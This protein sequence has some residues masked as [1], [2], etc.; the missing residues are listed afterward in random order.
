MARLYVGRGSNRNSSGFVLGARQADGASCNT[1]T[2]IS[3]FKFQIERT[4]QHSC[5][6][7]HANFTVAL[8]LPDLRDYKQRQTARIIG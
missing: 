1:P 6:L 4:L 7:Q 5:V 2:S 3:G 8:A